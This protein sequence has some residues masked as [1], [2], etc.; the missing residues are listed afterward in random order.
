MSV[1]TVKRLYWVNVKDMFADGLVK[2]GVDRTL[3]HNANDDYKYT[4]CRGVLVHMKR[5]AIS[6][7]KFPQETFP[8][9]K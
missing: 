9:E 2:C 4:T 6:I 3:L 8:E 7:V 1:P 5:T